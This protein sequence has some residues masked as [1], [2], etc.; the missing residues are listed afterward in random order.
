ME[1]PSFYMVML[2]RHFR[3]IIAIAQHFQSEIKIL[4]GRFNVQ[5]F[6][7][8]FTKHHFAL[9]TLSC[10]ALVVATM[11]ANSR[12]AYIFHNPKKPDSLQQL[13]KF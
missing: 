12:C 11:S 2:I 4:Q 5:M 1:N 6:K 9:Q 13:R 3:Y 7:R 8:L 10:M